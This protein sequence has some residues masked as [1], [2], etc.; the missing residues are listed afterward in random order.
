[1]VRS[2]DLSEITSSV[3]AAARKLLRANDAVLLLR[4]AGEGEPAR[5]VR[6]GDD[7]IELTEVSP[8]PARGRRAG[9]DP[10]GRA[11]PGRHRRPL[12]ELAARPDRPSARWP[13]PSPAPTA[14]SSARSWSPRPSARPSTASATPTPPAR[15]AGRPGVDRHRERH[16]LPPARA[17][18][19]DRAHQATH[20]PLTG[21]PNR[22]LLTELLGQA[23]D[24]AYTTRGRVGLI[25]VDLDSFSQVVDAFGHSS[26]DGLLIQACSRIRG[27]LPETATL[28]R[29]NGD[30]FAV[31][32]ARRG[33]RRRGGRRRPPADR[34]LRP[35]V[36]ERG[37]AARPRRQRGHRRLPRAGHRRTVARAAGPHRRRRRPPPPQ[38][39]GAVRPAARPPPRPAGWR[40]PPTCARRSRPTGSTSASSPRSSWPR[41]SCGAPRPWCAG[42]TP[43]SG[44][45]GPTSSSPSPSTPATSAR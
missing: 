28:A 25:V 4:P 19:A 15:H 30:Q 39:L 27:L 11:P 37:R 17:R 12:A 14:R 20:D 18:G 40:W 1:M 24:E 23:L 3:L 13:R 38:R 45:C 2:T 10:R 22:A 21:L 44:G 35:A 29:L 36:P 42:T 31:V 43:G 41:A 16:A 6:L 34:R 32:H 5:R 26:A 8:R 9:A 33:R 7:G